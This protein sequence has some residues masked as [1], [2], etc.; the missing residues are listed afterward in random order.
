MPEL[1]EFQV[2]TLARFFRGDRL[3]DFYSNP[4]NETKYRE[5]HFKK[6]CYYH[7]N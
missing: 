7:T 5:W 4:E 3:K 2:E 6:Y 1:N